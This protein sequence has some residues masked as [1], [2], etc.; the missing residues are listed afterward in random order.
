MNDNAN[1]NLAGFLAPTPQDKLMAELKAAQE[2]L[3]NP[4]KGASYIDRANQTRVVYEML[5]TYQN[6]EKLNGGRSGG[7]VAIDPAVI[8]ALAKREAEIAAREEKARENFL[9]SRFNDAA[10]GMAVV[11]KSSI[12]DIKDAF[13]GNRD[14]LISLNVDYNRHKE[15]AGI[16]RYNSRLYFMGVVTIPLGLAEKRSANEH[17]KSAEQIAQTVDIEVNRWKLARARGEAEGGA[18]QPARIAVPGPGATP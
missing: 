17:L 15:E 4:P 14:E 11:S 9:A 1:K 2:W 16:D 18:A 12:A 8:E 5:A 10:A 3:H 7:A 13:A 6:I